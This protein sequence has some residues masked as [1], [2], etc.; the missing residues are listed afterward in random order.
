MDPTGCAAP[1]AVGRLGSSVVLV[2][3]G[4]DEDVAARE[5]DDADGH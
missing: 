1:R 4:D 5:L 2:H 3:S